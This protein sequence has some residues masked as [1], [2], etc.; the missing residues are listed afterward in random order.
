MIELPTFGDR[1]QY[2]SLKD[3]PYLPPINDPFYKTRVWREFRKEMLARDGWY[4]LA[5]IGMNIDGRL[6]L[7]HI[8]PLTQED[9]D[10]LSSNLL[11]PDNVVTCSYDTHSKI[12]YSK[13]EPFVPADRRPGDT[14]LW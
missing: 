6:L 2:L 1:L 12:H 13:K 8:N 11:D 5:A 10:T 14:K 3:R 4:D 9:F 7:H